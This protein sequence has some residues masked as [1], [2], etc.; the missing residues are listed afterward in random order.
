M[1]RNFQV[2]GLDDVWQGGDMEGKG[3]G[4][5]IN[6]LKRDLEPYKDRE[7]LIIMF[8]DRYKQDLVDKGD[9]I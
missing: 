5:K 9:N 8:T 2:F 3:G 1:F 7:D 6:I 4:H